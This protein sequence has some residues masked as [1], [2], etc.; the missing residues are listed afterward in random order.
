MKKDISTRIKD[1]Y[2]EWMCGLIHDSRY[3]K[4]NTSYRQLLR[5]LNDVDFTYTISMDDNRAGDGIDLR[6]RFGYEFGYEDPAIATYLDNRPCSVLE[7]MVALAV[8]C[9]EHI[10]SDPDIGDR[11]GQW[12]WSMIHSLGLDIMTDNQ[13]DIYYVE[14]AVD[15]FLN[16]EY[17]RNGKGGLFTIKNCD[18]DMRSVEIWYQMCMYLNSIL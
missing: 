9:E 18:R 6:Y 13:F 11:T 4:H 2:F 14:E 1:E 17:E 5:Y 3:A 10:M 8:R 15:R 12:F 7:M 16:R